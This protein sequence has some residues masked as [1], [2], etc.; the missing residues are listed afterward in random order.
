MKF[1][2]RGFTLVELMIVIAIIGILAATLYPTMLG[3][4]SRGRDVVR[5]SD[6]K[7]LSAKYQEYTHVNQFYPDNTNKDGITSFCISELMLWEDAVATFPAK[8]YTRL[9]WIG[10]LRK[11]ATINNLHIGLCPIDWSYFYARVMK[12]TDYAVIVARMEN[13][14]TGANWGTWILLTDSGSIDEMIWWKP[15]NMNSIYTDKLFVLVTN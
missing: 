12:E 8:Q 14:T 13:Q 1:V 15:L 11:D 7:E 9:W 10:S 3:Y 5:I 2:A 6:I 4:M